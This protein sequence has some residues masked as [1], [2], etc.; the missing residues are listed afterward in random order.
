MVVPPLATE[1]DFA[2]FVAVEPSAVL[3][4]LA[5]AVRAAPH[6]ELDRFAVAKLAPGDQRVFDVILELVVR[7]V[8]NGRDSALRLDAVRVRQSGFADDQHRQRRVDR[9]RRGQSR[10]SA[11]Q[12]QH[13]GEKVRMKFRV[14]RRQV[15]RRLRKSN[16]SRPGLRGRHR[17]LTP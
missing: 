17:S 14:E 12:H 2:V 16:F 5:D 4:Q 11:A 1:Q 8:P 13:V 3:H 15:A 10:Q 6:D 9:K 7:N